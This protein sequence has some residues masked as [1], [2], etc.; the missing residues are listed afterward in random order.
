M[1]RTLFSVGVG[2]PIALVCLTL[3]FLIELLNLSGRKRPERLGRA[4]VITTAALIF[5]IV[6]RF[7]QYA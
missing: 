7:V 5:M 4:A 1:T 2:A 3:W 6:A